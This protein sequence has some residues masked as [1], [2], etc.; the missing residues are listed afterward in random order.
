[1]SV[2]VIF[3]MKSVTFVQKSKIRGQFQSHC[4]KDG[5]CREHFGHLELFHFLVDGVVC[6]FIEEC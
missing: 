5:F 3:F 1:M 2:P 6:V 4:V